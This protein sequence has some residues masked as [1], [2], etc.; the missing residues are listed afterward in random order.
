MYIYIHFIFFRGGKESYLGVNYEEITPLLVEAIRELDIRT[1]YLVQ[2]N[3]IIHQKSFI[4]SLNNRS[5][6]SCREKLLYDIEQLSSLLDKAEEDH[7]Q[8]LLLIGNNTQRNVSISQ[9]LKI[10][11]IIS[12]Q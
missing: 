3:E 4:S 5:R 7:R 2:N 11:G 8:L 1:S 12:I 10:A 9:R 6:I